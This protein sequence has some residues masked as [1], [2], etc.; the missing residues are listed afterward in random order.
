MRIQ[1]QFG[2]TSPLI[3]VTG[4]SKVGWTGDKISSRRQVS[5][6]EFRSSRFSTVCLELVLDT[7]YFFFVFSIFSPRLPISSVMHHDFSIYLL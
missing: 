1:R 4:A 7:L 5:L 6:G 3:P 2:M